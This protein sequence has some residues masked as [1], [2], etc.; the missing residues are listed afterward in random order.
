[1]NLNVFFALL[2]SFIAAFPLHAQAACARPAGWENLAAELDA[3][4]KRGSAQDMA[5]AGYFW[6]EKSFQGRHVGENAAADNER[7]VKWLKA[8]ADDGDALAQ[9]WLGLSFLMGEGVEQSD[10]K[11]RGW[12]TRAADQELSV[13]QKM[14]G[15]LA[16]NPL[17]DKKLFPE[18]GA[19]GWFAKAAAQGH[20]E[21]ADSLSLLYAN[22]KEMAKAAFWNA[23]ALRQK[24]P[25]ARDMGY[26]RQL[27]EKQRAQLQNRLRNWKPEP[28]DVTAT[29][30]R[31]MPRM[32]EIDRRLKPDCVR[33]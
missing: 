15:E 33:D 6:R 17:M 20:G 2:F 8:A 30:I 22:D 11:A 4:A 32:D 14:L 12:F 27:D 13:A 21:A 9:Y 7:A 23:I 16:A 29:S 18:K 24:A 3:K 25:G 31:L 26:D 1:M 28:S 5:L 19:A 10:A